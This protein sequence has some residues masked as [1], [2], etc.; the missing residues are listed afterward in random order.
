MGQSRRCTHRGELLGSEGTVCQPLCFLLVGWRTDN[1]WGLGK[2]RMRLLGQSP[3]PEYSGGP[4]RSLYHCKYDPYHCSTIQN[5]INGYSRDDPRGSQQGQ[6]SVR[7]QT[8]IPQSAS[9]ASCVL[10]A[11]G[12][13]RR[14]WHLGLQ[15]RQALACH[16]RA[17]A[18]CLARVFRTAPFG[19]RIPLV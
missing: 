17:S 11:E 14:P 1:F 9:L 5:I 16:V 8:F 4:L 15:D 19:G 12:A 10:W 13:T 7:I 18:R 2:E 6:V 3:S